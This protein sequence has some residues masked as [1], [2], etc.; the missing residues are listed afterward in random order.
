MWFYSVRINMQTILLQTEYYT[1][2]L[3]TT[4]VIINVNKQIFIGLIIIFTLM[5]KAY[6]VK[7]IIFH[8]EFRL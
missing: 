8:I 2:L 4:S 3:Y 6:M 1:R 5:F 7:A